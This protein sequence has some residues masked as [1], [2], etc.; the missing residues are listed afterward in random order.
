MARAVGM[1][2]TTC[3]AILL[4]LVEAGFVHR[5]DGRRTYALG[6]AALAVAAGGGDRARLARLT[7]LTGGRR[8]D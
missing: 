8:P 7:A 5:D 2:K 4:A 6:P 3:Q 1:D